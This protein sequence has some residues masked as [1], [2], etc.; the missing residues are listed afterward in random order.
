VNIEKCRI[1]N[2]M[3]EGWY[4]KHIEVQAPGCGETMLFPCNAWLGQSDCGSYDG[5]EEREGEL[6]PFVYD[7]CA[8]QC[9]RVGGWD[10]MVRRRE[11][12]S[13][14]PSSMITVRGSAAGWVGTMVRRDRGDVSRAADGT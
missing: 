1:R 12:G 11:R 4:L 6:H 10:T 2:T 3:D 7:G 9:S 8:W 13:C 5:E 14:I